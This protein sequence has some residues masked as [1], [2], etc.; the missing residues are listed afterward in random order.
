M[1]KYEIE[2][3]YKVLKENNILNIFKYVNCEKNESKEKIGILYYLCNVFEER[4]IVL[5]DQILQTYLNLLKIFEE[6]LI[7][8]YKKKIILIKKNKRYYNEK[9]LEL[10]F[11]TSLSILIQKFSYII[12]HISYF[13]SLNNKCKKSPILRLYI[14]Y[15]HVLTFI[16]LQKYMEINEKYRYK[17]ILY[18]CYT[19]LLLQFLMNIYNLKLYETIS[20]DIFYIISKYILLIIN[21]FRNI[22]KNKD[23]ERLFICFYDYTYKVIEMFVW[24]YIIIVNKNKKGNCYDKLINYY[25]NLI[26]FLYSYIEKLKIVKGVD[27]YILFNKKKIYNNFTLLSIIKNTIDIHFFGNTF[28]FSINDNKFPDFELKKNK[29]KNKNVIINETKKTSQD[30]HNKIVE[31]KENVNFSKI[32]KKI[33]D[34]NISM[35]NKDKKNVKK[36][37]EDKIAKRIFLN[38]NN[39]VIKNIILLKIL[40]LS[41][42]LLLKNGRLYLNLYI[43]CL[44]NN[45]SNLTIKEIYDTLQDIKIVDTNVCMYYRFLNLFEYYLNIYFYI[46]NINKIDNIKNKDNHNKY[47]VYSNMIKNVI[48]YLYEMYMLFILLLSSDNKFVAFF[49]KYINNEMKNN[50]NDVQTKNCNTKILKNGFY[51]IRN[52]LH[53]TMYDNCICVNN[54]TL[55]IVDLIFMSNSIYYFPVLKCLY[56]NNEKL[57]LFIENKMLRY[58]KKTKVLVNINK[59]NIYFNEKYKDMTLDKFKDYILYTKNMNIIS[60][61]YFDMINISGL[62]ICVDMKMDFHLYINNYIRSFILF[63]EKKANYNMLRVIQHNRDK[64]ISDVA[65]LSLEN[66]YN[67]NGEGK[68]GEGNEYRNGEIYENEIKRNKDICI[69]KKLKNVSFFNNINTSK[70]KDNNVDKIYSSLIIQEGNIK[71]RDRNLKDEY[72]TKLYFSFLANNILS[73][74]M[75][76]KKNSYYYSEVQNNCQNYLGIYINKL[77]YYCNNIFNCKYIFYCNLS[78]CIK[79]IFLEKKNNSKNSNNNVLWNIYSFDN[80]Q[81]NL[82]KHNNEVLLNHKS[83]YIKGIKKKMNFSRYDILNN[84]IN[85]KSSYFDNEN[86]YFNFLFNIKYIQN[87]NDNINDYFLLKKKQTH[88]NAIFNINLNIKDKIKEKMKTIRNDIFYDSNNNFLEKSFED[89]IKINNESINKSILSE[90]FLKEEWSYN[91]FYRTRKKYSENYLLSFLFLNYNYC[92]Y[93]YKSKSCLQKFLLLI[94]KYFKKIITH[95]NI[96]KYICATLL[97][98]TSYLEKKPLPYLDLFMIINNVSSDIS[99][100]FLEKHNE[101]NR[102]RKEIK[103]HL[104]VNITDASN[105]N[106]G[107]NTYKS[108]NNITNENFDNLFEEKK[109]HYSSKKIYGM[110]NISLLSQI[111]KQKKK[112]KGVK[113]KY[114][115]KKG[116]IN[117]KERNDI[118]FDKSNDS[119]KK[120]SLNQILVNRITREYIYIKKN[121][122]KNMKNCKNNNLKTKNEENDDKYLIFC[123]GDYKIILKILLNIVD[124][125]KIYIF[126]NIFH[127]LY[128]NR[129]NYSKYISLLS[130]YFY[131]IYFTMFYLEVYKKDISNKNVIETIK[132]KLI[133]ITPVLCIKYMNIYNINNICKIE[134]LKIIKEEKNEKRKNKNNSESKEINLTNDDFDKLYVLII[135]YIESIRKKENI[136]FSLYLLL[137]KYIFRN[138]YIHKNIKQ[139]VN[140]RIFVFLY[141]MNK[142][143]DYNYIFTTMFIL[144]NIMSYNKF[145][146]NYIYYIFDYVFKSKINVIYDCRFLVCFLKNLEKSSLDYAFSKILIQEDKQFKNLIKRKKANLIKIIYKVNLYITI[147]YLLFL[148][149]LNCCKF[150]LY[151]YS[152]F[153]YEFYILCVKKYTKKYESNH[154]NYSAINNSINKK[155]CSFSKKNK[156]SQISSVSRKEKMTSDG[157]KVES[158]FRHNIEA[159]KCEK[160]SDIHLKEAN[161]MCVNIIDDKNKHVND[162]FFKKSYSPKFMG[163]KTY[164]YDVDVKRSE[165]DS[166]VGIERINSHIRIKKKNE[167][168]FNCDVKNEKNDKEWVNES[169]CVLKNGKKYMKRNNANNNSSLKYIKKYKYDKKISNFITRSYYDRENIK[170]EE[171]GIRRKNIIFID[172]RYEKGEV[173]KNEKRRAIISKKNKKNNAI[174]LGGNK[175]F[176]ELGNKE[177]NDNDISYLKIIK[178][179]RGSKTY[180]YNVYDIKIG[181]PVLHNKKYFKEYINVINYVMCI[182]LATNITNLNMNMLNNYYIYIISKIIKKNFKFYFSYFY[183]IIF[184]KKNNR[185]KNIY[186]INFYNILNNTCKK[187]IDVCKISI[188]NKYIYVLN[189]LSSMLCVYNYKYAF[190]NYYFI[191]FYKIVKMMAMFSVKSILISNIL[192]DTYNDAIYKDKDSNGSKEIDY[193]NKNSSN[194][195][196]KNINYYHKFYYISSEENNN[197]INEIEDDMSSFI[198][199]I[200]NNYSIKKVLQYPE[201]INGINVINKSYNKDRDENRVIE[202]NEKNESHRNKNKK[203]CKKNNSL[204]LNKDN[205]NYIDSDIIMIKWYIFYFLKE[206][207]S[208]IKYNLKNSKLT[209]K[210]VLDKYIKHINNVM[211]L[212]VM[213]NY[214]ILIYKNISLNKRHII[215]N[216]LEKLDYY[217][218]Y[219]MK[220]IVNIYFLN[221]PYLCNYLIVAFEFFSNFCNTFLCINYDSFGLTNQIKLIFKNHYMY[222]LS[223]F[224]NKIKNLKTYYHVNYYKSRN[225]YFYNYKKKPDKLFESIKEVEEGNKEHI[226]S[227]TPNVIKVG[228]TED[229]NY[230][231]FENNRDNINNYNNLHSNIYYSEEDVKNDLP[232]RYDKIEKNY[233]EIKSDENK[234]EIEYDNCVSDYD[235]Y[236]YKDCF[237]ELKDILKK[238]IKIYINNLYSRSIKNLYYFLDFFN[239]TTCSIQ[240]LNLYLYENVKIKDIYNNINFEGLNNIYLYN[241]KV[242]KI[243]YYFISL[244]FLI[245]IRI[246]NFASNF[247]HSSNYFVQLYSK[248]KY[249]Y[250]LYNSTAHK[251]FL[252]YNIYFF[253]TNKNPENKEG[254]LNFKINKDIIN[255]CIS[256]IFYFNKLLLQKCFMYLS[257]FFHNFNHILNDIYCVNCL[258][259]YSVG[260]YDQNASP[261]ELCKSHEINGNKEKNIFKKT[262]RIVNNNI[263]NSISNY[264]GSSIEKGNNKFDENIVYKKNVENKLN[265]K[266][267]EYYYGM[268]CDNTKENVIDKVVNINDDMKYEQNDKLKNSYICG[269]IEHENDT[270][271]IIKCN[272]KEYNRFNKQNISNIEKKESVVSQT[273]RNNIVS[274]FKNKFNT[275]MRHHENEKDSSYIMHKNVDKNLYNDEISHINSVSNKNSK[276]KLDEYPNGIKNCY[277]KDNNVNTM[278][279]KNKEHEDSSTNFSNND[280]KNDLVLLKAYK[281]MLNYKKINKKRL[282]DYMLEEE[283]RCT[284]INK[285][286]YICNL[287][288]NCLIYIFEM[289]LKCKGMNK[290]HTIIPFNIFKNKKKK[291]KKTKMENLASYNNNNNQIIINTK[292]F[293]NVDFT[294]LNILYMSEN[295]YMNLYKCKLFTDMCI[296]NNIK[297]TCMENKE[298]KKKDSYKKSKIKILKNDTK[299]TNKIN[300]KSINKANLNSNDD[301]SDNHSVPFL[302]K[303]SSSYTS[304]NKLNES[305]CSEQNYKSFKNIYS[306]EKINYDDVKDRKNNYNSILEKTDKPNKKRK[307]LSNYFRKKK[308]DENKNLLSIY[309]EKVNKKKENKTLKNHENDIDDIPIQYNNKKTK[310]VIY[311]GES[312]INDKECSLTC[313]LLLDPKKQNTSSYTHNMEKNVFINNINTSQKKQSKKKKKKYLLLR[314]DNSNGKNKLGNKSINDNTSINSKLCNNG[315]NIYEE[316]NENYDYFDIEN[317]DIKMGN[318]KKAKIVTMKSNRIEMAVKNMV[319]KEKGKKNVKGNKNIKMEKE[320]EKS[321]NKNKKLKKKNRKKKKKKSI[322]DYENMYNVNVKG[323]WNIRKLFFNK[324]KNKNNNNK[325]K[326]SNQSNINDNMK[327]NNLFVKYKPRNVKNNILNKLLKINIGDKEE[328]IERIKNLLITFYSNNNEK[329][330]NNYIQNIFNYTSLYSN[331]NVFYK[332]N[333]EILDYKTKVGNSLIKLLYSISYKHNISIFYKIC[334]KIEYIYNYLNLSFYNDLFNMNTKDINDRINKY[335]LFMLIKYLKY[336]MHNNKEL[337]NI[338]ITKIINFINHN[339]HNISEFLCMYKY[340]DLLN[341]I[342]HYIVSTNI[343]DMLTLNKYNIFLLGGNKILYVPVS[344]ILFL[345]CNELSLNDVMKI[346]Y[347]HPQYSLFIKSVAVNALLYSYKKNTITNVIYLQL[348]EYLKVDLG[349]RI[350]FF[351]VFFSFQSFRFLYTFFMNMHTYMND[352]FLGHLSYYENLKNKRESCIIP[353]DGY[354]N[355]LLSIC[356]DNIENCLLFNKDLFEKRKRNIFKDILLLWP[357]RKQEKNDISNE[358]KNNKNIVTNNININNFI[359]FKYNNY[360]KKKNVLSLKISLI[361]KIFL[362]N[363]DNTNRDILLESC[364]IHNKIFCLSLEASKMD[365]NI[366]LDFV[367]MEIRNMLN[368]IDI[369]KI[370]LLTSNNKVSYLSDDIKIL[371]SATRSPLFLSFKTIKCNLKKYMYFNNPFKYHSDMFK[372]SHEIYFKKIPDI[373]S[374]GK[375][376][377]D[378]KNKQLNDKILY[379]NSN[380]YL[381]KKSENILSDNLKKIDY[382]INKI[383]EKSDLYDKE[384][385]DIEFGQRNYIYKGREN[386]QL[387]N[388]EYDLN[389]KNRNS[390]K[391]I[392]YKMNKKEENEEKKQLIDKKYEDVSYIYKVNDDVRQDKLVI[393]IIYIF[394][395]IFSEYKLFYNLFPYNIITNK[396]YNIDLNKSHNNMDS[397]NINIFV[398]N[399]K[400]EEKSTN[401]EKS[402]NKRKFSFSFHLFKKKKVKNEKM[403]D[404][405]RD[406]NADTQKGDIDMNKDKLY[407][408]RDL[409]N[410]GNMNYTVSNYI[411]TN[412]KTID[413]SSIKQKK[414]K[415]KKFENFGAVIEVLPKTKSRHEIGRKYQNIIKF[416]HLKFSNIYI[417]IYA[418][419]NF[420]SSLAAYSLMSFILQ[421]KDRHNG[422]LLFDEYGNIVHI[423]FGYIL[424]IYP[425]ISI[426]FELAPF[427]LT[428]EMIMLLTINNQRKQYFIF[429]YINLVVKGYLLLRQKS[430]WIISCIE[431]LSNSEINCFKYNTIEKL[432]KRL[433]L[434]KNDNDAS[435]FMINKIHQAYN[436]ITTIMYDYIQNIQQGIQ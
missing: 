305:E 388:N 417:Y 194:K 57:N 44:I 416:Y 114:E 435:I 224:S 237:F 430:D 201:N 155:Q 229:Q 421:V 9:E 247:F 309:N 350:F 90:L 354:D 255:L 433:N 121:V 160:G 432:K 308:Q 239:D 409:Q 403:K 46:I 231:N 327:I 147:N 4:H 408:S 122:L 132:N 256:D 232:C 313:G 371:M 395:H 72:Y 381:G 293:G 373:F 378:Y 193:I 299:V 51:F 259:K 285:Y 423:D 227:N 49:F 324:N 59:K 31:D 262:K 284:C 253:L 216:K 82:N 6:Y 274:Y 22:K 143:Y 52:I 336:H 196:N 1:G 180:I 422:N 61:N 243:D 318:K 50:E 54:L 204:F 67:K 290:K 331:F 171:K 135:Y 26:S 413:I 407:T 192:I 339:I 93:N 348:F 100:G 303:T 343:N 142:F 166:I 146:R 282:Y 112:K 235:D 11:S 356:D 190:F 7:Q 24:K 402:E 346:L 302:V 17:R 177:N 271:N 208:L 60:N 405:N 342:N 161:S 375:F 191:Y 300:N 150:F 173:V 389:I 323:K 374:S 139:L 207:E 223:N 321:K 144:M 181:K 29:N 361:K 2:K 358:Y 380:L 73:K 189:T 202:K 206:E 162:L 319:T 277:N 349:N 288:Y 168:S 182:F 70:S 15:I 40:K 279:D 226:D 379:Y 234:Y 384:K 175:E 156:K 332:R 362:E 391:D 278:Y 344:N 238:G 221:I 13:I 56:K 74:I 265:S 322:H 101:L 220:K 87:L 367:K 36:K 251:Y 398:K 312:N 94:L 213:V 397:H 179:V 424:N 84:M 69:N 205:K 27:K 240:F 436:N 42:I 415:K 287:I 335:S 325:K 107:D 281:N 377:I 412:S 399:V 169:K 286:V 79:K 96:Y 43:H 145:I 102:L 245:L 406:I 23:S 89:N 209:S 16:I 41:E 28:I 172:R 427:K 86:Y 261:I 326:N 294:I 390:L 276:I 434:D 8:I 329:K 66:E 19:N 163:N 263:S 58:F 154:F 91:G 109:E 230:V 35:I 291:N 78:N 244:T 131:K 333:I 126:S 14:Y 280:R 158:S 396:Y 359:Y 410:Y 214:M 258:N 283:L 210:I 99:F 340:N 337:F 123:K 357:W 236:I 170:Y 394:I 298:V 183:Y 184:K 218:Y 200:N 404:K 164:K 125:I 347:S 320:N 159:N 119:F 334:K 414:K 311:Q 392:I 250:F 304:S 185:Y 241:S 257:F 21:T 268:Y 18:L 289:K 225:L 34:N 426:N 383:N 63:S 330:I 363:L 37:D 249:N 195:Y 55:L 314:R 368:N 376:D 71:C 338:F 273:K 33:D 429:T 306:N 97:F 20:E 77:Q 420:I 120:I 30:K 365:K 117:N 174:F 267:D 81:V 48:F 95:I 307:K 64:N 149:M 88:R 369:N 45:V 140:Y 80:R 382:F 12:L 98:L 217:N 115:D 75:K 5:N 47:P 393:Q 153:F 165:S 411:N 76:N 108:S 431:S 136:L 401:N 252:F 53:I 248:Y 372:S 103:M 3:K 352:E 315:Q 106:Q 215:K 317:E 178:K 197:K 222:Y 138:K 345:Y 219:L 387:M 418:L 254:L 246:F 400:E 328:N 118:L 141:D 233:N 110:K 295:I 428:K 65:S 188:K 199:E 275:L 198:S 152:Y 92:I 62:N 32:R 316:T 25:K 116:N 113:I 124:N 134:I 151:L 228:N 38:I 272:S 425:G 137:D 355:N 386:S 176:D 385:Y 260:C 68:N 360:V 419:K 292:F 127:Y 167:Y 85:Y 353:I 105:S 148:K 301:I 310:E 130:L 10:E 266:N 270:K 351:I 111:S 264:Y 242:L 212:Y 104:D 366:Q 133:E 297:Y 269:N 83:F 128:K 39:E 187:K 364:R 129:I 211:L 296:F 341:I 370:K 203:K 157:L 186:N